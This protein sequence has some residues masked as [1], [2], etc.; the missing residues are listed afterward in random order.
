MKYLIFS[1][2]LSALLNRSHSS[3]P[4]N[5]YYIYY[6]LPSSRVHDRA[7]LHCAV[8]F[9]QSVTILPSS[10]RKWTAWYDCGHN[11]AQMLLYI[12]IVVYVFC[13]QGFIINGLCN[14]KFRKLNSM[15]G[16]LVTAALSYTFDLTLLMAPTVRPE[17]WEKTT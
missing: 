4:L 17:V 14:R 7:E 15:K 13:E 11:H 3:D 10:C 5:R 2:I 8:S 1:I 12:T 6:M 16:K 9:S